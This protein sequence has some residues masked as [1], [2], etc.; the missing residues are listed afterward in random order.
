M[1]ERTWSR[2]AVV[3]MVAGVAGSAWGQSD[4]CAGAPALPMGTL[5][6]D[7][8]VKTP[9]G[10]DA[11]R[12]GVDDVWYVFQAPR[13][14]VL[15]LG[16]C[17]SSG[18]PVISVHTGC[19]GNAA[20]M[21]MCNYDDSYQCGFR[22][23][24]EVSCVAGG[25]YRVRIG[26]A[27]WPYT[28][29]AWYEDP[30]PA[31]GVG[32][33]V[34]SGDIPELARYSNA[35]GF[36]A[37]AYGSTACNIGTQE[38]IWTNQNNSNQHPVISTSLYRVKDGVLE[39]LGYAWLKHGW[40][41]GTETFCDYC[42]QTGVLPVLL[43]GC[44][45]SYDV[46]QNGTQQ[47]LSRR[48]E[49]NPTT[50]IFPYPPV[51][52]PAI[53]DSTSRRI[54]VPQ[55]AIDPAQNAGAVYLGELQYVTA[56][57]ALADNAM[58]NVSYRPMRFPTAVATP[59]FTGPVV[60]SRPA[61]LGWADLDP[62]VSVVPVDFFDN[63]YRCRVWVA[64]RVTEPSPGVWRYV[65]A[66]FNLNA[67]RGVGGLTLQH[68]AGARVAGPEARFAPSHSGEVYT[69]AAW[70]FRGST[71]EMGWSSGETYAATPNGNAV[72]WGTTYTLILTSTSGPVTGQA[73]LPLYA[74]GQPGEPAALTLALPVPGRGPCIADFN[75]DG[76]ADF[77]DYDGFV[78]AFES[79]LP[80]A[81]VNADDFLDFFDYN[82]YVGAF[83]AGC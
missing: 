27:R 74:P 51:A 20:N 67:N 34:V 69:N 26:G 46:P 53:T 30:K 75:G 52:N 33:D 18:T 56:D 10:G 32:P 5:S 6:V 41:S 63:G 7:L 54:R 4:S 29:Q 13:A 66:V 76:F 22:P 78:D 11:C 58:N 2:A 31:A 73:R 40:A 82:D 42:P 44:S 50:G 17:G 24:L 28:I 65:Y 55:A 37:L 70:T 60:R 8:A 83:E 12:N 68:N 81:D 15:K 61:V 80:A 48:S 14:G 3:M 23:H 38:A 45:D 25:E 19:P 79:G 77:F 71:G 43:P 1:A 9:D 21:V 57:D 72:R 62:T 39:Q 59:E 64:S 36:A 16:A 47:I 49:V 35:G